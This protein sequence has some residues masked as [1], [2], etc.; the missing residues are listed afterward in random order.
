M[1]RINKSQGITIIGFLCMATLVIVVA[2]IGFRLIPAYIENYGVIDSLNKLQSKLD[3]RNPNGNVEQ[4][5][6]QNA[7]ERMFNVNYIHSVTAKDAEV[8]QQEEGFQVRVVYDVRIGL[9]GN[10]SLLL[11]FD[12]DVVIKQHAA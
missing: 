8:T 10:I 2:L 6:I 9:I 4:T 3:E 5:A 7:L 1:T 12:D 11:H